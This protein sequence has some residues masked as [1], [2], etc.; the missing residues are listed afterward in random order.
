MY[1]LGV[2]FLREKGMPLE[3][4]PPPTTAGEDSIPSRDQEMQ[5]TKSQSGMNCQQIVPT[6][7]ETRS[8]ETSE[9]SGQR[10]STLTKKRIWNV[11][12]LQES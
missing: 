8:T 4:D 3:L 11:E 6:P 5:E 9:S 2:P 7:N 12:E 1:V 10:L